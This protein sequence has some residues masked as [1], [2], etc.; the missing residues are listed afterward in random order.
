MVSQFIIRRDWFS[1]GLAFICD[2]Y[3][4]YFIA[5]INPSIGWIAH[6]VGALIGLFAGLTLIPNYRKYF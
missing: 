6:L 3:M 5:T 2:G 1:V 4:N